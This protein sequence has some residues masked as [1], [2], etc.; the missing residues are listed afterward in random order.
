MG[1]FSHEEFRDPADGAGG[2]AS[3]VVER[4]RAAE[5]S[6][7]GVDEPAVVGPGLPP[8]DGSCGQY[9]V[10]FH[11]STSMLVGLNR[12]ARMR[13]VSVPEVCRQVIG[14]FVAQQEGELGALLAAEAEAAD[15]RP[16][17]GQA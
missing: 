5:V 6:E 4:V 10:Q 13:G 7:Y 15:Y 17:L 1:L 14:V 3:G 9:A 2:G 11:V 12:I 16:S 8:E